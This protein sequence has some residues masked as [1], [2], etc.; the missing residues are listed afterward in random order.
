M[1]LGALHVCV[2]VCARPPLMPSR[3]PMPWHPDT[4]QHCV[5]G[6]RSVNLKKLRERPTS[7]SRPPCRHAGRYADGSCG[8]GGNK[9]ALQKRQS[10]AAEQRCQRATV[11]PVVPVVPEGHC[12]VSGARGP[13]R[14]QRATVLPVVWPQTLSPL[15]GGA[16]R[17]S[18]R[19]PAFTPYPYVS[20]RR[21]HHVHMY[22]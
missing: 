4:D 12:G 5:T 13:L 10:F 7:A 8:Q 11:L 9:W 14:C 2:C 19:C 16:A 22:P 17:T 18:V 1:G 6:N 20:L 21:S 15:S 3:V